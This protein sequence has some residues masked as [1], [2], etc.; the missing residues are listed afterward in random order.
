MSGRHIFNDNRLKL[1]TFGTN[2]SNGCAISTIDG[3]FQTNWSEAVEIS[4]VA[5]EAG[6]EALI[7]VA[8]WRGFG[9]ETDFNGRSFE[10]WTWAA[11]LGAVTREAAL[12]T[13]SHVPTIHPVLAAKQATTIDHITGGRFGINI[14]CGWYKTE[15]EMFGAPIMEHDARYDYAEEWITI[16]KRLWTEEDDLDFEGR[17]F[18][19]AKGVNKPKP[20]SK[21]F[22]ALMCAATSDRGRAFSGKHADMSFLHLTTHDDDG[23]RREVKRIKDAAYEVAK[24][25]IQVWIHSYCVVGDTE[26]DARDF[27]NYYVYEKGD[28]VAATNLIDTL[29]MDSKL[30]P[31]DQLETMR[32]HFIA[33][34]GGYPLVGTAEQIVDK[35]ANLTSLGLAGTLLHWPRYLEG[36][37]QFVAEVLPLVEQA[38]LRKPHRPSARAA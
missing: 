38:G 32:S 18:K 10:T 11:G 19:I 30:M 34:W 36:E 37:K 7:P 8:R 20:I 27:F 13:T 23:A 28:K 33:G 22:P 4:R 6:F 31:A 24:R 5:D 21:P 1:G 14:V 3:T 2:V 15:I 35:L 25:D 12:F 26:K 29:G 9:G 17:Y 16:M